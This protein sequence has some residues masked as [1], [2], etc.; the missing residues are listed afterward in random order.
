MDLMS[1]AEVHGD[2]KILNKIQPECLLSSM[3]LPRIKYSTSKYWKSIAALSLFIFCGSMANAQ[4]IDM[5]LEYAYR[6][7]FGKMSEGIDPMHGVQLALR[8][9]WADGPISAGIKCAI[10]RYDRHTENGDFDLGNNNV[11][12]TQLIVNH[13]IIDLMLS[14]QYDL[15]SAGPLQPYLSLDAGIASFNSALQLR[16]PDWD[17]NSEAPLNLYEVN[18]HADHTLVASFGGGLRFD[19]AELF[20]KLGR[21]QCFIN[22]HINYNLGPAVQYAFSPLEGST[23]DPSEQNLE[24]EYTVKDDPLHSTHLYKSIYNTLNFGVGVAWRLKLNNEAGSLIPGGLF[25]TP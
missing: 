23:R 14:V 11:V 16:D 1:W 17:A 12:S 8:Y 20:A 22:F 21:N 9:K 19:L 15:V 4:H 10:A 25:L 18:L 7:P 13:R 3:S 5:N 6:M 2:A 24:T